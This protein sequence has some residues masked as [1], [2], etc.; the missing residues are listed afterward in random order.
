MRCFHC[1]E[2]MEVR[3]EGHYGLHPACFRKSFSVDVFAEGRRARDHAGRLERHANPDGKQG[4]RFTYEDAYLRQHDAVSVGPELPL[5]RKSFFSVQLF[6]SFS[7]RIPSRENPAYPEYCVATGISPYEADPFVLLT[8]IGR[9]GPSCLVFEPAACESFGSE[10][11]REFRASLGL[12]LRE[13]GLLFDFSPFTIQKVES[14]K[15]TGRDVLRR[16]ELYARFPEAAWFEMTRNRPKVHTR[17]WQRLAGIFREKGVS[18]D[19]DA[20]RCPFTLPPQDPGSGRGR[21]RRR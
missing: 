2:E 21:T 20:K 5:T 6:P 17:L 4:F 8:T 9:R 18:G 13:F 1:G 3:Q 12:S 19:H 16:M 11:A 14:G 7:D 10:E 15:Q